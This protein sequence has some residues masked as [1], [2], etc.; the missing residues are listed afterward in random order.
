MGILQFLR[1]I[2]WML[3][4]LETACDYSTSLKQAA[5]GRV[6]MKSLEAFSSFSALIVKVAPGAWV[7]R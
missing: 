6:M 2:D 3:W 1:V 5:S 4:H 7:V